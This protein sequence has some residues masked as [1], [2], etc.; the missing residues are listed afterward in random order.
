MEASGA[1]A[2]GT[3][4]EAQPNGLVLVCGQFD[5]LAVV[6]LVERRQGEF[7]SENDRP[8]LGRRTVDED[9][10]VGFAG[11]EVG[12]LYFV[13]GYTGGRYQEVRAIA[14][15]PALAIV[16]FQ[17]PDPPPPLKVGTA[18]APAAVVRPEPPETPTEG[19]G[20]PAEA[21]AAL[22]EG[23]VP[24]PQAGTPDASDSSGTGQANG[25]AIEDP[26]PAEAQVTDESK[27][28]DAEI[29]QA[30]TASTENAS[31]TM[32]VTSPADEGGKQASGLSVTDT[33][34]A[35][36]TDAPGRGPTVAAVD[37]APDAQPAGEAPV[38]AEGDGA[39]Q[40]DAPT[41][42]A[43]QAKV[44]AAPDVASVEA[45]A[46]PAAETPE[47]SDWDKLVKQAGEVGVE[48]AS[49]LSDAELRQA[50]TEKNTTPVV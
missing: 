14:Q 48:N 27:S 42:A 17:S 45:E 24:A 26:A 33:T 6:E 18:G 44:D 16:G 38:V 46:A 50:I 8:V 21:Q 15:D 30:T 28:P 29:E 32:T 5:P 7:R 43:N 39:P 3:A 11:L 2:D 1:A 13:T 22:D 34:S 23:D 20:L 4:Q 37:P 36:T 31:P 19:E 9:G 35:V 40:T 47:P 12:G 10:D 41:E 25:G 49:T